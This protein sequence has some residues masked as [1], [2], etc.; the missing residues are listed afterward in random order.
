MYT[1]KK[2]TRTTLFVAFSI[3]IAALLGLIALEF[4]VPEVE[5]VKTS[6]LSGTGVSTMNYTVQLKDNPVTDKSEL[7]AGQYYLKPFVDAIDVDCNLA[8]KL[9]QKAKYTL[10]DKID[11]VLVSQ[12]GTDEEMKVIWEKAD[13][14]AKLAEITGEGDSIQS[15]RNVRVRFESYDAL[16]DSL[17]DDYELLTDYVV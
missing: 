17:I 8:L 6:L 11:V 3:I 16:V 2:Q 15:N 7:E 9:D 1:L 10:K 12:V 13:T 14:K 5:L 4:F